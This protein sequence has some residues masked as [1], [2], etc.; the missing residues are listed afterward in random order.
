MKK[1]YK[2]LIIL[3]IL[4]PLILYYGKGIIVLILLFYGSLDH[5]VG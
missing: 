2:A 1:R 3:A 4:S 5:H